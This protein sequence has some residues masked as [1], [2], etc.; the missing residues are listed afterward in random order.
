MSDFRIETP[1]LILRPWQDSDRA[2]FA[3]MSADPVFRQNLGPPLSRAESDTAA[4]RQFALQADHGFCFWAAQRREDAKFIGYCGFKI[5]PEAI[6]GIENAIEI[7]WGFARHAQGQGY[8]R[9][10]AT[11]CLAW[12]FDTRRFDR[13]IAITTPGNTASWGLMEHI[14][15]T[16]RH[17]L[18]FAH[19]AL[20]TTDPL[21]PHITY[22]IV[23]R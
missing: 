12:G 13:I 7:G 6:A 14:G 18:D 4:D 20:A 9:E 8:A 2:P 11:A 3:I 17:D 1:R 22:E 19:P 21:S 5:A 16:R 23:R 10:A 15:M